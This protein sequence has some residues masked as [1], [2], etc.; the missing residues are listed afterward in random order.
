M[1][2]AFTPKERIRVSKNAAATRLRDRLGIVTR[3]QPPDVWV[4]L[5]GEDGQRWFTPGELEHAPVKLKG[6]G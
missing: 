4:Q 1:T 3:L 2:D 6:G 5:D